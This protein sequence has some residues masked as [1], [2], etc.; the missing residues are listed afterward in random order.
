[1]SDN[2]HV[3]GIPGGL[4]ADARRFESAARVWQGMRALVLDLH[5]RRKAACDALDMSYIRVKAL[6]H[7]AAGAM[8]MRALAA[9]LMI[10]AP[11]TT[12]VVDD[13]ER[14]GLVERTAHPTDRRS[15]I[16]AVTPAGARAAATAERVLG[17]P[18]EPLLALDAA[19]LAELDRILSGL[20]GGTDVRP[21]ERR[22]IGR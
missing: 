5:D 16:V 8:T 10:D 2:D 6:L 1:M 9:D 22:P 21:P 3:P 13:L 12:V 20:L 17:E 4:A 7:L 14:R 11:Y 15:K 19:D 18:P